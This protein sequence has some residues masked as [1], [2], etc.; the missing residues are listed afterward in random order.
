MLPEAS[1]PRQP[2]DCCWTCKSLGAWKQHSSR[3]ILKIWKQNDEVKGMQWLTLID[4][5][6]SKDASLESLGHVFQPQPHVPCPSRRL[7]PRLSDHNTKHG[8]SKGILGSM[9]W[10]VACYDLL[11]CLCDVWLLLFMFNGSSLV[12]VFQVCVLVFF[13]V[14]VHSACF[15]WMTWASVVAVA[16]WVQMWKSEYIKDMLLRIHD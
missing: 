10:H 13:D 5:D 14:N 6:S 11:I 12:Y 3:N 9:S 16:F 7:P 1:P 2:I 15:C 8:I 4:Q